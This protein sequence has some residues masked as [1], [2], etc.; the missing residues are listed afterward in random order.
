MVKSFAQEAWEL[1]HYDSLMAKLL[2]VTKP[3]SRHWHTQDL[4]RRTV[5]ALLFLAMYMVIFVQ[6]ARGVYTL[7][8]MV[9]LIQYIQLIRLPLFSISFYVDNTQRAIA[10][11]RDYFE[12]LG[13]AP[14]QQ[15]RTGSGELKVKRGHIKFTDVSFGYEDGDNVLMGVTF[16]AV[17]GSKLALVGES[18]EG[19]TTI[20]NLLLGLDDA[21]G[22]SITIDEQDITAVQQASLR[23]QI[24]VVFQ[25]P[26]L[27]SGT[28]R[29]NITYARPDATQKQV[30]KAARAANAHDFIQKFPNGYDTEIGERGLELSG[31]QKQR[32]AIARALLKERRFS[33][34]MRQHRVSIARVKC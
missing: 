21:R 7:G 32:I 12:V 22:G 34:W 11:S 24:G 5:L 15:T 33:S 9:L 26:A 25:E 6:T 19:K 8:T 29:E 20:T 17:P 10:N 16:E 4:L 27:F 3:Q 23:L 28:V 13:E 2:R 14:E 18:G 31:G 30:E 1:R